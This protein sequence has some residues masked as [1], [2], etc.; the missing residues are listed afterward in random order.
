V[1]RR[2]GVIARQA[3]G[4]DRIARQNRLGDRPVL[5]P[6]RAAQVLLDF[7]RYPT[8]IDDSLARRELGYAP[9]RTTREAL[10]SLRVRSE[11]ASR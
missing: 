3:A 8:V 9:R 5:V 7:V 4:A 11:G 1:T 10:A 6:N 2:Q